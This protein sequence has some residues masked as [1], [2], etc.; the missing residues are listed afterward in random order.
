MTGTSDDMPA[1]ALAAAK[2]TE[3]RDLAVTAL[4]CWH[5]GDQETA[6]RA[7]TDAMPAAAAAAAALDVL[8]ELDRRPAEEVTKQQEDDASHWLG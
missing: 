4:D 5:N 1:P 8:L 6:H 7:A 2:L 3:L